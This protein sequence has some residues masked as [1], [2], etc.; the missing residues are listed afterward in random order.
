AANAAAASN[1]SP[2]G[3]SSSRV[4]TRVSRSSSVVQLPQFVEV[5]AAEG[6]LD[7]G[8]QHPQDHDDEQDVERDAELD[9]ER[10]A[11]GGQ[12]RGRGDAVVQQQKADQLRQRAAPAGQ[13]EEP[14]QY[15]GEGDRE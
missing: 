13:G 9:D 15:H 6:G 8:G 1:G 3:A 5:G 11:G 10:H 14:D 2:I 12:E 7:A 4:V